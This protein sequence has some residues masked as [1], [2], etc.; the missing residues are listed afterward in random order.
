MTGEKGSLITENANNALPRC[1]QGGCCG[2]VPERS[3]SRF[4]LRGAD[5]AAT[6]PGATAAVRFGA[7]TIDRLLLR[8]G[9]RADVLTKVRGA[10]RV[11]NWNIRTTAAAWAG[12]V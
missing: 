8:T 11:R 10:C 1:E 7:R 2:S 6:A 3:R 9:E 5:R 4:Y 12:W